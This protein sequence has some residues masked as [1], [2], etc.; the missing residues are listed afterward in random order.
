VSNE[1]SWL[2]EQRKVSWEVICRMQR[3]E[4]GNY[5][6]V[7]MSDQDVI[8]AGAA[9]SLVKIL[10]QTRKKSKPTVVTKSSI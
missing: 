6:A 5:P 1:C 2:G 3:F 10:C 9:F 4:K 8:T 7:H